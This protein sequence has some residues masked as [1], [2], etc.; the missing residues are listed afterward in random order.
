MSSFEVA[1]PILNGP[2]DEPVEYWQIEEGHAPER[3]LG[4]RSAGYFYRDPKAPPPE[5]GAPARGAWVELT[6]VNLI[7]ERLA[8]WRDLGYPGATRTTRQ[9]LDYW[10]R[11]GRQNRLFFA[12]LEAAE[13]V[14][15][16]KEGRG[17]LLQGV[18]IP[19]DLAGDD[20]ETFLR[21]ACKMATGSGKTT[22]MG[23][24][25]AWSILNKV[26]SRGD[27]RYSDVALVVCPNVT[28][29]ERLQELDP[30]RG[31]ASIYRTRDLVP[32]E[33]MPSLRRGRVLVKNWHDF[34]RKGMSAGS[35]VQKNGVPVVENATIK[36][37]AKTTSGRGGRYFTAQAF[38]IAVDSGQFRVLDDRRP[39]KPEVLVE[40]TRFVESDARLMQ[41]LL[42][43][44]GGK[45]NILVFNDEAHHAYR[46]RGASVEDALFDAS[47]LD[48]ERE[49]ELERESTI[50]IDGLDRIHRNR[51]INFCIDLSATPYFLQ[52]A[53]EDTNKVFPWV[54][55]DFGLTDAIESGLVK[56]PQLAVADTTGAD[57]AAYFNIWRWIM[58]QLTAAER[59]GKR[60]NPKP[61]AV[62]K[63]AAPPIELLGSQWEALR[64]E[65]DE[66][67]DEDRP[68]VFILVCKNTKLA[69]TLYEW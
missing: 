69:G 2:F 58:G 12:Q 55:S 42:R 28:I 11:D 67:S 36:I 27:A 5:P 62:L 3:K 20:V 38:D 16:L 56:I 29:R 57:Q 40:E 17:D 25:I 1:E 45:Q 61:E 10:Q 53:G 26:A 34:E 32:P 22:V 15:F 8:Q 35:R 41:R 6:L 68:P 13:T 54:V 14:V 48:E 63:W 64:K 59:G 9:L 30:S 43:E 23:M 44:V 52:R 37:G 60:A 18:A 7:R 31:E 21:Y 47:S 51:R 50:W 66:D 33:L 39:D 19:P 65:W 49:D 46:I 4:R 24:L